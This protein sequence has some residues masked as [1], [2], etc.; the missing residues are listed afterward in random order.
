MTFHLPKL[1]NRLPR[2]L[3]PDTSRLLRE[4][5][6]WAHERLEFAYDGDHDKIEHNLG[7]TL[8]VPLSVPHADYQ[9]TLVAC[10]FM[11][12]LI[13]IENSLV[14]KGGLG[15]SSF[16]TREVFGRMMAA[17]LSEE[18][19]WLRRRMPRA[20][21]VR[22][23]SYMENYA[24]GFTTELEEWRSAP[25]RDYDSYMRERRSSLGVRW[26]FG[27]AEF[28][29]PGVRLSQEASTHPD[30]AAIHDTAVDGYTLINDLVSYRKELPAGDQVNLLHHLQHSEGL[31]LQAAMNRVCSL[32]DATEDTFI[33]LR[34]QFTTGPQGTDPGM[35][36][37]L[38]E[39]GHIM[40]S[41]LRWAA[42]SRRYEEHGLG[43]D[44]TTAGTMTF[45]QDHAEFVPRPERA[46]S[47]RTS[48][49]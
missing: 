11:N 30:M 6:A 35:R 38:D 7:G 40:T 46:P 14:D 5:G 25:Y 12:Y 43:W 48:P 13:G 8:L 42:I 20:V 22:F 29:T 27:F 44:G 23:V 45:H 49:R 24:Y 47:I 18:F 36:A 10:K 4:S 31:T 21:W 3:H 39:I 28:G 19:G 16:A 37:Y 34:E 2:T 33:G 41:N 26:L 15:G 32:I 9:L 17:P 1:A